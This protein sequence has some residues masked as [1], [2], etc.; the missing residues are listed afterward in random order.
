LAFL[1]LAAD[2][3]IFAPTIFT[4][5]HDVLYSVGGVGAS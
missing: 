5:I 2:V 4:V 3:A 1:T